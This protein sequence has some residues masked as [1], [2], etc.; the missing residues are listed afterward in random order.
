TD[1]FVMLRVFPKEG[2]QGKY[3]ISLSKP[4]EDGTSMMNSIELPLGTAISGKSES[5]GQE[6]WYRVSGKKAFSILAIPDAST[7]VDLELYWDANS[8]NSIKTSSINPAGVE[9]KIDYSNPFAE[10]FV[11]Y[12]KVKSKI[13]GQYSITFN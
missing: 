9:E 1:S 4:I 5:V 6:T 8:G 12:V 2:T 3:Q 13:P 11:F 7:D 10:S